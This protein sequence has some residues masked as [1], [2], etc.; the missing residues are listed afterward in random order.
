LLRSRYSKISMVEFA[1]IGEGGFEYLNRSPASRGRRGRREPSAW[2][3]NRATLFLE[4]IITVTW[5]FRL[6]SLESVTAKYG[7]ESRGIRT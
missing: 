3:Y 1:N 4:D 7:H 2:G 5:P 6:G